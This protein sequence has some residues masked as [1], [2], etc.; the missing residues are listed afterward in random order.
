MTLLSF[1]KDAGE[2]L[3]HSGA[4]TASAPAEVAASATAPAP[5][6]DLAALNQTAADAIMKYIGSQNL[7]TD[8]LDLQYDGGTATVTV[9]GAVPDQAT[10]EKIVLCCGNVH[11]VEYVDDR[12]TVDTPADEARYYTVKSGDTLSKISREM[13]GDA[14]Q[15][16]TIFEANRPMLISADRIYPGQMLRVPA[17]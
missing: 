11:S 5:A 3:F 10:H 12:I 2:K 9:S 14:N 16:N 4:Q 1:I 6:P 7:P 15:Y 8:G 13:Y 17:A